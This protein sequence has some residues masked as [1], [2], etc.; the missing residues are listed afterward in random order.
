MELDD[1]YTSFRYTTDNYYNYN[2]GKMI[3]D[4]NLILFYYLEFY[5]SINCLS[6]A[7][8]QGGDFI[9]GESS[10]VFYKKLSKKMHEQFYMFNRKA[11][12]FYRSNE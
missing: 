10:S 11:I 8:A 4:I 6:L 2:E 9:G 7:F 12:C 5:K 1:D 3:K